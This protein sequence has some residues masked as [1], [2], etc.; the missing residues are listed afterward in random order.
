LFSLG[1]GFDPGS[2]RV[3]FLQHDARASGSDARVA[4]H[5]VVRRKM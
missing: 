3:A 4:R 2:I 1:G 5:F